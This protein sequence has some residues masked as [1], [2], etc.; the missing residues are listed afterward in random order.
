M[1]RMNYYL[2]ALTLLV[3]SGCNDEISPAGDF[4]VNGKKE[5]VT[6]VFPGTAQGVVPYAAIASADENE[7]ATLDA[8]VFGADPLNTNAN[9]P[10]LLEDVFKLKEGDPGFGTDKESRTASI[11]IIGNTEKAIFFVANG[12]TQATLDDY[13]L[14]VTDT[15]A[16]T[17]KVTEHMGKGL[18]K[19][20]LL[21]TARYSIAKRTTENPLQKT[22]IDITLTRRVARFDVINDSDE[23]TFKIEKI[24]VKNARPGAFIFPLLDSYATYA[25]AVVA[26]LMEIDFLS[27]P[28]ANISETGSVLYLYPTVKNGETSFDFKGLSTQSGEKMVQPIKMRMKQTGTPAET[29]LLP[30]KSNSRYIIQMLATGSA[31]VNA[32]ITVKEWL[33]GEVVDVEAGLGMVKLTLP[34]APAGVVLTESKKLEVPA[35]V[36]AAFDILVDADTEW[37]LDTKAPELDWIS[38][39]NLP[40][41]GTVN[42]KF[43]IAITAVNPLL[44]A[45]EGIL[46][47]RNVKRPAIVQAL[48]IVQSVNTE[49]FSI[50]GAKFENNTLN[51]FGSA[52]KTSI[53]ITTTGDASAKVATTD[54]WITFPSATTRAAQTIEVETAANDKEVERVGTFTI[55]VGELVQKVTVKQAPRNLGMI[56]VTA[57]G[58]ANGTLKYNEKEQ[59]EIRLLVRSLT[60]WKVTAFDMTDGTVTATPS[61]WIT[62]GIIEYTDKK[63]P[64]ANYDGTYIFKMTANDSYVVRKSKMTLSNT[65]DPTITFEIIVE[66]AAKKATFTV[67]GQ[68]LAANIV[69]LPNSIVEA[70]KYSYTVIPTNSIFTDLAV[71][72]SGASSSWLTLDHASITTNGT[73]TLAA[74]ANIGVAR[75]ATITVKMQ[76]VADQVI[77]VNQAVAAPTFTVTGT[78]LA[79]N[80][81][82]FT[83]E[84]VS[85]T[86]YTITPI[87]GTLAGVT[88]A[89]TNDASNWLTLATTS[90]ATGGKF[91][92][93][94]AANT[95]VERTA[96]I[97]VTMTG[98]TDQV[99]TVTQAEGTVVVPTFTVTGGKLT[100]NAIAFEN[101]EIAAITYTATLSTGDYAGSTVVVSAAGAGW[102]TLGE[103][104]IATNGTFTLAAIANTGV[105]RTATVTVTMNGAAAQVIT[106]TQA[107]VATR[108]V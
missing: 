20:P 47:I 77:T 51:V 12:R 50:K 18:V 2:A 14:G 43:S 97:T 64:K 13:E 55:T 8:Y 70:A 48:T 71:E 81:I 80:D 16:F 45:R 1:K 73:F 83:K 28:T 56:T 75:T 24:L 65:I 105:A 39:T 79:G 57:V 37:T 106:V 107:A 42:D 54:S 104:S 101:T 10:L 72:K 96:T 7:I 95:G 5:V 66:Q 61:A 82:T 21:M 36:T 84:L 78:G 31:T 44:T 53:T 46:Y 25:E 94:A 49:G 88:V 74:A 58:L 98:A 11:S 40:T 108:G 69:S 26:E 34:T 3:M 62:D 35:T 89:K 29:A 9:A 38:L 76:G 4:T 92:L 15:T 22:P 41:G 60:D 93:T 102:L 23:S 86:D 68:D 27:F 19:C 85:V 100:G 32:N 91:T 59:A 67:T 6:F 17:K 90:L 33:V 87:N 30:I 63:D 99:I 52:D 103:L